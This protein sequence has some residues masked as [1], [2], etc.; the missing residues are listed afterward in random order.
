MK[1]GLCAMIMSFAFCGQAQPPTT[2]SQDFA[3]WREFFTSVAKELD[4][5]DKSPDRI[6]DLATDS[7]V[8]NLPGSDLLVLVRPN[9]YSL[10]KGQTLYNQLR[11]SANN[12]PFYLL[13]RTDKGLYLIGRMEG[14][15]C[16]ST[17]IVSRDKQTPRHTFECTW[18]M[19]AVSYN[20]ARYD[21]DG[22]TLNHLETYSV[23]NGKRKP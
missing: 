19:S 21:T 8:E 23:E 6:F 4:F 11:G 3:S 12:G 17:G 5:T 7:D 22:Q 10:L 14:N 18:H 9:L 1:V 2:R 15:Q 20:V 13:K 16:K